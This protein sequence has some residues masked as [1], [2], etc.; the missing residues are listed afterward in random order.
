M[1]KISELTNV[2]LNIYLDTEY[3]N[4]EYLSI[5]YKANYEMNGQFYSIS[6]IIID[7]NYK[8]TLEENVKYN[9]EIDLFKKDKQINISFDTLTKNDISHVILEDFLKHFN[10]SHSNN[11]YLDKIIF[12]TNVFFFYAIKDISIAFGPEYIL[13]KI[14]TNKINQNRN[15][16]GKF[17]INQMYKNIENVFNIT[18]KDLSGLTN[19]GLDGFAK[20][21]GVKGKLKT[22]DEY[23]INMAEPLVKMPIIFLEYAFND[24]IIL[25]E[26]FELVLSSFNNI[27]KDIFKEK[28]YKFTHSNINTT[29][30][31]LVNKLF[32]YYFN[33]VYLKNDPFNYIALAKVSILN[34][35][36]K[37]YKR[38]LELIRIVIENPGRVNLEKLQ[39]EDSKLFN[40]I[41][42]MC[43]NKSNFSIYAYQYCS[44]KF[45]T[46]QSYNSNLYTAALASVSGGRTSNERPN[47]YSIL[48]GCDIDISGAYASVLEEIGIPLNSPKIFSTSENQEQITL[49]EFLTKNKKDLDNDYFKILVSGKLSFE[50]NI[51]FS[52]IESKEVLQKAIK[53]NNWH[54]EAKQAQRTSALIRNEIYMGTI[55]NDMLKTLRKVCSTQELKEIYE[56]K[57]QSALFY[58]ET[59]KLSFE[60]FIEEC[61]N[62]TGE[63]GYDQQKETIFDNRTNCWC[64]LPFKEFMSKLRKL[65][66]EYKKN[67]LTF[68]L[69]NAIKLVI[70]TL[71][72]I[73]ASI[74]FSINNALL[75]DIIT[76]RIRC[77]VW[78]LT[79]PLGS[80]QC[81]T[82][83]AAFDLTTTLNFKENS[84][85][86]PSLNYLSNYY[87][88][89]KH[90]SME[91]KPLNNINWP[92]YFEKIK[93][94]I[95]LSEINELAMNHVKKFWS[96]YDLE[97]N[98]ETEIKYLFKN[99][100]YLSKTF[101]YYQAYNIDKS[102]YEEYFKIRSFRKSKELEFQYP[103]YYLLKYISENQQNI[104][105]NKI[106]YII[107]NE[108][109]YQNVKLL[110][111][112][113]YKEE[114]EKSFKNYQKLKLNPGDAIIKEIQFKMSNDH[115]FVYTLEEHKKRT[116]R[117]SGKHKSLFDRFLYSHGI[118]YMFKKMI[119]DDLTKREI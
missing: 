119:S 5:Q 49:G 87:S 62:C 114:R 32:N 117:R 75:G 73:L 28:E 113:S 94:N 91:L 34:P 39:K 101:Y 56:L 54:D 79:T 26:T 7:D 51:L 29:I 102:E 38:N 48:H 21:Y 17:K 98:F 13:D 31:S 99:G 12:T 97:V 96:N 16:S 1:R 85:I 77:N 80:S 30:G 110:K 3:T 88:L 14:N 23:K 89:Q 104:N 4:E 58:P 22:L 20:E 35:L 100:A 60:D 109:K 105:Y 63:F 116:K 65:R 53:I 107:P 103:I 9:E 40:E 47:E 15:I 71:F 93:E 112:S 8:Q 95:N 70:N 25:E 108:G 115:F 45:L 6:S 36:N 118:E 10:K 18:L 84:T 27:L 33:N 11:Q 83:G 50:Q 43:R 44:N 59:K 82:D 64:L 76:T 46:K 57:V 111:I 61:L 92:N 86:K 37:N 41:D 55:T 19:G 2:Y 69:N 90:R 24:V 42:L 81:I 78:L 66:S 68:H 52:R 74:F 106:P 67:P 72:G